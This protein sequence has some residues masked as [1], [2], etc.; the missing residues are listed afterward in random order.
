MRIKSIELAW[1]RGAADPVSLDINCNSMVVYGANGAGKSSFVDAVEY[2]LNDGSIEHL[3]HEY[4]TSFQS[5][6]IINTCKPDNRNTEIKVKFSDDSDLK[7]DFTAKGSSKKSGARS[8]SLD[9]WEYRQTI[10]R[11]NEVS[12]FIHNTKGEKYSALLPLFGLENMEIAA[13][14]IRQ[15]TRAVRSEAKLTEKK[16]NL[17]QVE[18]KR[19]GILGTVSD[20]DIDK[21]ICD[22]FTRY[23]EDVTD[24][25]DALS[26]CN[27]VE[28]AL[29]KELKEHS[30]ENQKHF[31]LRQVADSTLEDHVNSVR[32]SSVDLAGSLEPSIVEKLSVL[33][34]TKRFVGSIENMQTVDC[35]ACGR[36][37][38]VDEFINHL[39][40]ESDRLGEL[41]DS[42]IGYK[43]AIS[44]ICSSLDSLKSSLRRPE[45]SA[46]R[47]GHQT[48]VVVAGLKYIDELDV[49]DF[50][51]NCNGDSINCLEEN[52]LSIIAAANI[53]SENAPPDVHDLTVDQGKI[54]AAK[55]VITSKEL[56]IDIEDSETLIS[57]L[58]RLE[59]EIREEIRQQSAKVIASIS[60]DL[61]SMWATLHPEEKIDNVRLSLPQDVDKAID[62]ALKFYGEDQDSPRLTLSEGYRNSLGLCIFLAM[63]KQVG[64]KERPLFLDDVVVSLDRNHRGM[65]QELLDKEF[66]DR[67]VIIFTHERDWF[68]ELKHQLDGNSNW[69]FKALLPYESP[70]I[71]IRWSHKTTAFD[72]ARALLK[73]RPD[74]SGNDARKIMDAELPLVAERLQIKLPYLRSDRNDSRMAHDFLLR[75]I[76][77]GKK[78]FQTKSGGKEYIIHTDA[79]NALENADH[80]LL[81]WGNKA[82]HSFDIVRPEAEKLLDA[83]EDALSHFRCTKCDRFVWRLPDTQSELL[84]CQCSELR[85]RYGKA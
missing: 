35:P 10:L 28:A 25:S 60:E 68:T 67:Q 23:C 16:A 6:A 77:D 42:F 14:N 22:L 59:Q 12:A 69:V 46:W 30:T 83:C 39:N 84:Q 11:Q 1:F 63:A 2:L 55:A 32:T 13:E 71:G 18:T 31:H 73:E 57:S 20:Q 50:R 81:S 52:L 17:A 45:L 85:W 58:E 54:S 75:L 24:T 48:D 38:S 79:I 3:K 5:N 76:A 4:S 66:S 9:E 43:A 27:E 72:D 56:R 19:I 37:I 65:I 82:S 26:R 36:T 29:E 21:I 49:N 80:L 41:N 33:Q 62:I 74:S 64:D 70:E 44:S 47:Q 7:V 34:S 15:I 78:C 8:T 53:D 61:E 51:E 40:S